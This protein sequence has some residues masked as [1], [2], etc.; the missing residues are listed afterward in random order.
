MQKTITIEKIIGKE[1]GDGRK[2]F[3]LRSGG[4]G[5]FLWK[6]ALPAGVAE[7]STVAI[8]HTDGKYPKITGI[9]PVANGGA[10]KADASADRDAKVARAVALK[11]AVEMQ[12]GRQATEEQ[13]LGTAEKF[14]GWLERRA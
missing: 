5:Y 7:G 12:S 1:S 3:V 4:N 13:V 10:G 14:L 9:G 6:D 8:D 2:Y 11:A